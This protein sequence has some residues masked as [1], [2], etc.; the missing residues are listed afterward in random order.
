MVYIRRDINQLTIQAK[1]ERTENKE[2]GQSLVH[3]SY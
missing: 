1:T 3:T 2:S